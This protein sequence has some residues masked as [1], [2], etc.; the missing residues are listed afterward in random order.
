MKQKNKRLKQHKHPD[1]IIKDYNN[2]LSQV[3]SKHLENEIEEKIISNLDKIVVDGMIDYNLLEKFSNDLRQSMLFTSAA[4]KE[5]AK[6]SFKKA[7]KY[8]MKVIKGQL[9]QLDN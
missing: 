7:E 6:I 2:R 1:G 4:V 9:K 5:A 3:Y 8:N